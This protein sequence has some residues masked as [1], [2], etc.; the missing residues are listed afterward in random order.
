[1]QRRR[2]PVSSLSWI[3]MAAIL[4]AASG[5][6]AESSQHAATPGERNTKPIA[7]RVTLA[8]VIGYAYRSS[9][10][11]KLIQ[12]D[13]ADGEIAALR[14]QSGLDSEVFGR[15]RLN[16]SRADT[17]GGAFSP[18]RVQSQEYAIG[19]NRR[20]GTGTSIGVDFT[21]KH[22][23]STYPDS[24]NPATSAF[25]PTTE[26]WEG[27]VGLSLRQSL[28]RDG[29][30]SATRARIDAARH[31]QR[32][33]QA[34]VKNRLEDWAL[35]LAGLYYQTWLGK[36]SWS[37]AQQRLSRQRRLLEVTK[38]KAGRGTADRAEVLQMESAVLS[39]EVA[40]EDARQR[41]ADIWRRL[42]TLLKLS[43]D[44]YS[45]DLS[46]FTI[47][48]DD[49]TI[50]AQ[51]LCQQH[52][53]KEGD[54]PVPASLQSLQANLQGAEA[55]LAA[56]ASMAKPDLYAELRL[57]SNGI[58]E[59]AGAATSESL[60]VKNPIFSVGVGIT[61]PLDGR[62]DRANYMEAFKRKLASESMLS[63]SQDDLRVSWINHCVNLEHQRNKLVALKAAF[64]KQTD[65]AKQESRRFEIGQVELFNVTQAE[66][67][68]LIAD[69][70]LKSVD[71]EL[72]L[73]AWQI[74]RLADRIESYIKDSV[75]K[76]PA[77]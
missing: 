8:Q 61:I 58:D 23:D 5:V 31:I 13:V 29:F 53:Q 40:V 52:A 36:E 69:L 27:N 67:D 24:T 41:V 33:T 14:A 30:G 47:E 43:A 70:S 39:A 25:R 35:G 65:R 28:W 72:R 37:S 21:Q 51:Q 42:V 71:V 11:A 68:M 49:P 44:Y 34:Q 59:G 56:S 4:P 75:S 73:S 32:G 48:L 64:N 74:M 66:N 45:V 12:L 46:K 77:E 18:E 10:S 2:N 1:M 60:S 17:S 26:Y 62:T 3:I 7:D 38:I 50:Q 54:H 57:G 19:Y 16:D 20:L 9:D 55:S 6:M 76:L 15:A 22:N 63:Q